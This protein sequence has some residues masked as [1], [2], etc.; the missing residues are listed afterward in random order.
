MEIN[1]VLIAASAVLALSGV[2]FWVSALLK[3]NRSKFELEKKILEAEKERDRILAEANLK[4]Q[5]A[6]QNLKKE[7]EKEH[8]AQLKQLRM[9]ESEADKRFDMIDRKREKVDQRELDLFHKEQEIDQIK[10]SIRDQ[11]QALE[12]IIK[13]EQQE[14]SQMAG[15]APE[16]AKEL[17]FEKMKND[18]EAESKTALVKHLEKI[19]VE[20]ED[21]SRKILLDVMQRLTHDVTTEVTTAN[22]D[23]PKE[24]LKGKIIGKEGRNIRAFEQVSGVD[25][26]IDESPD[27]V[28][29]SCFDSFRREIARRSMEKLLKDGRIHPARIEEV[30]RET[31]SEIG[32]ET[33]KTGEQTIIEAGF[34]DV[35]PEIIK[36]FGRLKFR[37][38]YG[39][40]QIRHALQVMELCDYIAT[41]LKL[42]TKLARRC[43]LL[44][45]I[46]KAVDQGTEGSHPDLGYQLAKKYGESDIVC[47]AI[48]AHHEGVEVTSIYTTITAIADAISAARPGARKES[49][50]KYFE[51]LEKLENIAHSFKG[52][53][54]VY[55]LRAGRELRITVDAGTISEQDGVLLTR[56][57]AKS[58]EQ[59]A[60]YPGEVKVTLMRETRY[61]EYAR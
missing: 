21:K 56:D 47:N 34:N 36:L 57:I 54:K 17:L 51:R 19:Q 45:D 25:V 35:H 48:A 12:K 43:G 2:A 52:V 8:R 38:S 40:N 27:Y 15:L 4:A 60:T 37:H 5:D 42:D 16:K 32:E 61:I 59:E 26:I 22:V 53:N 7:L 3:M 49:T 28:V 30:I 55:A 50:Q 33:R 29:I 6:A 44:H 41:E 24:E 14:L 13:K 58:I 39:Q 11:E 46:G 1:N 23:L 10:L 18:L 9:K 20:A 31:E